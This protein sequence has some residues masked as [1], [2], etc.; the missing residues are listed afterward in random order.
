MENTNSNASDRRKFIRI[1]ERVPVKLEVKRSPSCPPL[2]VLAET[3]EIGE[4]G[5]S[6]VLKESIPLSSIILL[7]LDLSPKYPII[8]T[9]AQVVWNKPYAVKTPDSFCYGVRFVNVPE[10]F[11]WQ[12][13]K[14]ISD[15]LVSKG[16]FPDR[17]RYKRKSI[18][19]CSV[20]VKRDIDTVYDL[21]KDMEQFPWF[22]AGVDSVKSTTLSMRK[23]LTEWKI[24]INGISMS[25]KE[26]DEFD[27]DNMSIRFRMLEGSF[28]GYHGEWR[29]LKAP[30]GTQISFS[31]KIDWTVPDLKSSFGPILDQKARLAVRWMLREIRE[32]TEF[33]HF[34]NR[35][36]APYYKESP[37]IV[38]ELIQ[39]ENSKGKKII[40]FYDYIKKRDS[41]ETLFIIIP[42]SYGE[43]KKDSLTLSYYLV[44]NGFNVIRYD[45]TDHVGESDGEII[46]YTLSNAKDDLKSTLDFAENKFGVSKFGIVARSLAKRVSIKVAGEDSRV[47]FIFGLV[48]I[49]DLRRTLKAIHREDVIGAILKGKSLGRDVIDTFGFEVSTEFLRDAI[50]GGYHNLATTREDLRKVNIPI[51]FLI[52][53]KDA[54]VKIKDVKLLFDN[55]RLRRKL[56]VLPNTMHQVYENPTVA[57]RA[58]ILAV[59]SC[60]THLCNKHIRRSEVI[61]P[62]LREI[63]IQNRI[64]KDRL[65]KLITITKET[66]KEFWSR[67]L[68]NYRIINKSQEYR[69]FMAVINELLGGL[70]EGEIILDAGCG[71][72]LYGGWLMGS[73][74]QKRK[75]IYTGKTLSYRKS[76]YLGLD[77]AETALKDAKN[78][79]TH[80]KNRICQQNGFGTDLPILDC[81]YILSD[82]DY[83]L[84]FNNNCFD[85]IC[86]NLV[87]SYLAY[88]ARTLKELF[89]VLKRHGKVVITSLKPFNDLSQI[90][91]N[92]IGK[93][94]NK[95]D[96]EEAT[97]LFTESGKIKYKEDIGHYKFFSEEELKSLL[98]NA[99]GKK[100]ET[101]RS[102]GNQANVAV[103]EKG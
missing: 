54:W 29:L 32:R 57:K 53:E 74:L 56:Y 27:K 99:K 10:T 38:S 70:K 71:I 86:C 76:S 93:A 52:A 101:Y 98:K 18:I 58:L 72:G 82:L 12:L 77:F 1:L 84:P 4:D 55:P 67:Y 89:R 90:Y 51:T 39:Y 16:P 78:R 80:I 24:D 44:R 95:K 17:R 61:E 92:F 36:E 79:H 73:L 42:P 60:L 9:K 2:G 97:K 31:V 68:S 15:V 40:G 25:W 65:R 102:F 87:L 23:K 41:R 63:A 46:S 91:C 11:R 59:V 6:L 35:R 43:T 33:G 5:L 88:P 7:N 100:I 62:S 48:G 20:I 50:K 94:K 21:L 66:E 75:G 85:K 45:G 37:V 47:K 69:N 22:I 103:A 83:H 8:Q 19:A 30:T 64:E 13:S 26:E 96:I 28:A 34:P 81:L 3:R 49:V 14:Y